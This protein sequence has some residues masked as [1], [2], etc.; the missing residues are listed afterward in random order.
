VTTEPSVP[1][2]ALATREAMAVRPHAGSSISQLV[3]GI[4]DDLKIIARDEADLAKIEVSKSLK[5]SSADAAVI[6]LGGIVALI[7]LGLLCVAAVVA[8]A[9]V[10]PSLALRLL[11]MAAVYIVLGG[12]VVAWFARR[13]R[14]DSRPHLSPSIHEAKATLANVRAAVSHG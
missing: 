6:V 9:P 4:V 7:G 5:R 1:T 11:L 3:G 2:S 12:L 10:I 8:L 14:R 13:L